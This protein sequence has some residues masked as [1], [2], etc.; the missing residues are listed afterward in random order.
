MSRAVTTDPD[1]PLHAVG[2]RGGSWGAAVRAAIYADGLRR[3]LLSV[4]RYQRSWREEA[5]V[6]DRLATATSLAVG[7]WTAAVATEDAVAMRAAGRAAA[8]A[9]VICGCRLAIMHLDLA[10]RSATPALSVDVQR[11]V[12]SMTFAM[13][14]DYRRMPGSHRRAFGD[15]AKEEAMRICRDRAAAAKAEAARVTASR[16]RDEARPSIA[17][18]AGLARE[19]ESDAAAAL[20]SAV[21]E[22]VGIAAAQIAS[23]GEAS[24]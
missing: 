7:A 14:V 23:C 20:A 13:H 18:L 3:A 11:A 19:L 17:T 12:D 16:T 10:G 4:G 8:A 22:A 5:A 2:A 15:A 9:C 24:T 21:R 1:W 6:P